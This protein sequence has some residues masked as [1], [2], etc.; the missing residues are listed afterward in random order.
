M[1]SPAVLFLLLGICSGQRVKPNIVI[2]IGSGVG[3][4]DIGVNNPFNT[5]TPKIN[6]LASTGISYL[7]YHIG[8]NTASPSVAALLTG[9]HGQRNGVRKDFTP[10]SVG[11]LPSDE[12]TIADYLKSAGYATGF[13]GVWDMGHQPQFL[14]LSRGFDFFYGTP[15]DPSHGC[16]HL[17][18]L[19]VPS[20]CN[21]NLTCS[22]EKTGVPLMEGDKI[23]EQP[24]NMGNMSDVM[25]YAKAK[26]FVHQARKQK[27]PFLLIISLIT[28]KLPVFS[29]NENVPKKDSLLAQLDESVSMSQELLHSY[30]I[31]HNTISIFTSKTGPRDAN[32]DFSGDVGPY[33]GY[34]QRLSSSH[35][36]PTLGSNWE[37]ATRVPFVISW[38]HGI[39]SF[40][41]NTRLTSA[42]DLVPTL[43]EVIGFNLLADRTFDGIS[44]AQ[45]WKREKSNDNTQRILYFLE[46]DTDQV[47]V[48]RKDELK[49]Y[50]RTSGARECN[51]THDPTKDNIQHLYPLVFDLTWDQGEVHNVTYD[52]TFAASLLQFK[53]EGDAMFS[54]DTGLKS[55]ADYSESES[56]VICCNTRCECSSYAS[57]ADL[58]FL[59]FNKLKSDNNDWIDA[60]DVDEDVNSAVVPIYG[61]VFI[62]LGVMCLVVFVMYK[63]YL[64]FVTKKYSYEPIGLEDKSEMWKKIISK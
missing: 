64:A 17:N 31:Q 21:F 5:L 63:S 13:I 27:K 3:W 1:M 38:P 49:V 62:C 23:L 2:T 28:I 57:L 43:A 16:V 36:A 11:G 4:G 37:G 15:Y 9:R 40:Y 44:M 32:C 10:L 25:F 54:Q 12:R 19:Y 33:A 24:L 58:W 29:V 45:D 59:M 48:F 8:G 46:P 22:P 39:S 56:A 20:N 26:K 47:M 34:W 6:K 61:L 14:P 55:I 52:S 7:D 51:S 50:F 35:S 30:G 42:V 41:R 60:D 53:K 18:E